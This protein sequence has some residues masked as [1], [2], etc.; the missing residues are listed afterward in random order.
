ML[1]QKEL[2]E[3]RQHPTTEKIIKEIM[4]TI[5]VSA[6]A[7]LSGEVIA[8]TAEK[9]AMN[10]ATLT[11]RIEGLTMVLEIEGDVDE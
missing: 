11:G 6:A 9:T 2:N 5:N 4:E 3:W 7:V 10:V 1:T 8:D